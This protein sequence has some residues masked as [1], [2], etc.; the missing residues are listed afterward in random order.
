MEKEVLVVV[1][2]DRPVM[3]CLICLLICVS[4]VFCSVVSVPVHAVIAESVV[5]F[6]IGTV[7]MSA[8]GASLQDPE[9]FQEIGKQM[10]DNFTSNTKY[11]V[12]QLASAAES[13]WDG[14]SPYA[15]VAIERPVFAVIASEIGAWLGAHL[16]EAG[17]TIHIET[18]SHEEIVFDTVKVF[19]TKGVSDSRFQCTRAEVQTYFGDGLFY[20]G[21][22]T[23]PYISPPFRDN[24]GNFHQ[25]VVYN[26]SKIG[27]NGNH[28]FLVELDENG[29][30]TMPES[31]YQC[32][33][34]NRKS[35]NVVATVVFYANLSKANPTYYFSCLGHWPD[36]GPISAGGFSSTLPEGATYMLSR[37]LLDVSVDVGAGS[38]DVPI[39]RDEDYAE[40]V[41]SGA[42]DGVVGQVGTAA[43]SLPFQIPMTEDAIGSA[44]VPDVLPG[45]LNDAITA[46]PPVEGEIELPRADDLKLPSQI[47]TKFPFCIPFDLKRGVELLAASPVAPR[48]EIPFQLGSEVNETIVLDFDRFQTVIRFCRWFQVALFTLGL[49]VATRKFIKW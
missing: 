19:D 29:N 44:T 14:V 49:A 17:T 11:L 46:N 16:D 43:E 47:I 10:Y 27:G 31:C 1:F 9:L 32:R 39:N 4:L 23:V 36:G 21:D 34:N 18:G 33:Y 22:G 40:G 5:T 7:L 37:D 13:A 20:Y 3:R 38:V 2:T 26:C 24:V 15:S 12:D 41:V 6:I 35:Y 42:W 45:I 8:F 48:F 28:A 25:F 30:G